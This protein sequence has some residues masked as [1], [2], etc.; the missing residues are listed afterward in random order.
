MQAILSNG[1]PIRNLGTALLLPL[2]LLLILAACADGDASLTPAASPFRVVATTNIVADWAKNIGGD[3]VE[4]FSVVP[5]GS[6]P[7]TF[8]PGAQDAAKIADADLLLSVGLGLEESWLL[9]LMR[10]AVREPST[11]AELGDIVDPIEF[12]ASH[13]DEVAMLEEIEHVVYEVEEGEVS[14]EAALEEVEELLE[15]AKDQESDDHAEEDEL[16]ARVMAILEEVRGGRMQSIDAIGAIENLIEEGEDEHTG[17]GHGIN[18]PHFWFDPLR[19]KRAVDHIAARLSALDPDG[20]ED[21]KNNASRYN[22]LLDELHAWTEGQV[23]TIPEGRRRLITSHDSLGYFAQLY[24][25]EVLA[26]VLP[27]ANIDVEP[28]AEHLADLVEVVEEYDVPAIFGE[29][30][31]SERLANAVAIESG[32]KLVRLY[33]GSL[34]SGASSAATYIGMIQINVER[35]VEAL[36]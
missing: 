11:I 29:T 33:S 7:H 28:S 22:E 17:H 3:R 31:V 34:D 16:Y 14:A 32:A 25:F 36:R 24:G 20:N 13:G 8:R 2:A 30:T 18:D 23:A 9:E 35:I 1:N 21:Y 27:L 12:G 15:A 26:T 19:V 6:D 4:V 10:N 5:T